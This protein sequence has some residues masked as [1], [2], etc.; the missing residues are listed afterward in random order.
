LALVASLALTACGSDL[1]P[2]LPDPG[3]T[4]G[5]DTSEMLNTLT[6]DQAA[7]FCDWVAGRFGGY[8]RGVTC[9]NG[10][11]ISAEGSQAQ[12]IHDWMTASPNCPLTVGDFEE[13]VN[14]AIVKPRCA[15][16]PPVCIGVVFCKPQ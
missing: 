1:P 13:C 7:A 15:S 14:G 5:L 4:S 16:I 9:T 3:P 12:C 8:G 6:K 2:P 10:T 11:S